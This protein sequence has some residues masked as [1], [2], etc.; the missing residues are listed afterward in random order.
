MIDNTAKKLS[1]YIKNQVPNH[2]SS[3]EVLEY[4]IGMFLNVSAIIAGSILMSLLTGNTVEVL[5]ILISFSL[6]R[7]FSG[8]IHLKSGTSCAVVSISLFTVISFFHI[9]QSYVNVMTLF[10]LLIV[11]L[12]A[13]SNFENQHNVPKKYYPLLKLTSMIIV[14]SNFYFVSDALAISFFIQAITLILGKGVKQHDS[15]VKA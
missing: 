3:T 8:G 2:P 1:V 9:D 5:I 14:A 13:P 7:Q 4:S 15:N 12:F 6:L 11:F 10:T